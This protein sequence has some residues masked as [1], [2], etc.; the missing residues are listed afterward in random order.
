MR[1]SLLFLC[2]L[3]PIITKGQWGPYSQPWDS[4]FRN[5]MIQSSGVWLRTD[6]FT[7]CGK[8]FKLE[9]DCKGKDTSKC[10]ISFY[11]NILCLNE[12]ALIW[13]DSLDLANVKQIFDGLISLNVN[14]KKSYAKRNVT[15]YILGNQSIESTYVEIES[16]SGIK[17]N[18]LFAYGI[19]NNRIVFVQLFT[20]EDIIGKK[21]ARSSFQNIISWK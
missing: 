13:H 20:N 14:N 10:C 8:R 1:N 11:E 17:Q 5:S 6:S 3:I 18:I 15:C 21:N 7:F 4:R 19:A 12:D 2:F 9:R 16:P